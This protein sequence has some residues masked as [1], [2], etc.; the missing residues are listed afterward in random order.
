MAM[1]HDQRCGMW[2]QALLVPK[3]VVAAAGKSNLTS[4]FIIALDCS[5]WPP[6]PSL[7]RDLSLD[8]TA[9][10]PRWLEKPALRSEQ[11]QFFRWNSSRACTF[12]PTSPQTLGCPFWLLHPGD[13]ILQA[14]GCQRLDEGLPC[15]GDHRLPGPPHP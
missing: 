6:R 2:L 11:S 13:G 12:A 8:L 15:P 3:S 1:S 10:S 7:I 14:P 4:P 5:A 9:H